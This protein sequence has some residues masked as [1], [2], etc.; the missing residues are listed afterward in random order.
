MSCFK[1]LGSGFCWDGRVPG[2]AFFLELLEHPAWV[3]VLCTKLGRR[4]LMDRFNDLG[5][6]TN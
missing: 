6:S 1:V 3:K 5:F 4:G 2:K